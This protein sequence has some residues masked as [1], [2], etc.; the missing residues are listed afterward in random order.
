MSKSMLAD[1]AQI[2]AP[3]SRVPAM[4]M[5]AQAPTA[6]PML[7]INADLSR[8]PA[9]VTPREV[10]LDSAWQDVI[11]ETLLQLEQ[12]GFRIA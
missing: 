12:G 10:A 6:G 11:R 4:Q 9:T 1:L 2:S 5:A 7:N 8:V 3:A